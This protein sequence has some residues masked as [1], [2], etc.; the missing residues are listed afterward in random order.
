MA[1]HK[2]HE[3]KG[4]RAKGVPNKRTSAAK[5]LIFAAIDNQSE[6]FNDVML[7]LKRDE[8]RE[9]ARIMVKLM[10]FVLPKKVDVTTDGESINK[11]PSQITL[12]NG[13]V[14]EI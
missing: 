6:H 8:P 4:G 11:G 12:S 7:K 1:A 13:T 2:G 5:D 3:K 9:W 10:D 14:I